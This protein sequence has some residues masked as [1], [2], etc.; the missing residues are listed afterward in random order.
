MKGIRQ[1]EGRLAETEQEGIGIGRGFLR[2]KMAAGMTKAQMQLSAKDPGN[3][4][5]PGKTGPC[6]TMNLA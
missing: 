5:E 2:R 4:G 3:Q 1:G 6:G